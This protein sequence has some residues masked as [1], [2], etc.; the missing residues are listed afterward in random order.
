[1]R[2]SYSYFVLF[3]FVQLTSFS[4]S[5]SF[6]S[7]AQK[8]IGTFSVFHF[9]PI[10]INETTSSE[11]VDLFVKD[12]DNVGIVLKQSDVNALQFNKAQLFDQ[13]NAN[14]EEYFKNAQTI[15]TKALTTVDS[16]LTVLSAKKLNFT[17]NDTARSLS[18]NAKTFYS[19]SIKYH[20]KRLER[21]IKSRS[22]DRVANTDGYEKLTELEFNDKASEFSKT[23]ITNFQKNI[24]EML[25]EANKTVETNLLNAIALRHDPHSN[26]FTQEQN[27]EFNKQL[28]A[29][30]ESFGFYLSEDD[31]GNIKV[32]YIEPG[33]SAW[34]SNE[35]NEGDLFISVRI[36]G[37]VLT[38]DGNTA[39]DIQEKIDKT[40]ENKL[41]LTL[42]K[43]NGQ[44]KTVKL[45]KQ[46]TASVDNTVKG[47]VLKSKSGNIGYISLPSFY[48]DMEQNTAP[49]CA[50]DVAKEILKLEGDSITGLIIDIRNNG[51]GSMLEA[52]N[53]AGIFVDEGPLFIYKE[54]NKKPALVKDINRGSI[55]K[56]PLVVMI[57]ETSASASELFSNIVKDYNLGLVVGQT[58]YGKGTAQNVYP[59]DTNVLRVRNGMATATDFIKVTQAKFYRL[60]NSTHQGTGVV[61]DVVL[62]SSPGYSIYKESKEAFFLESDVV[63]KNVVYTPNPVISV[64][65]IQQKSAE[66]IQ[67]STDFKRYKQ[68][69]DSI[70]D[71]LNNPP[72]LVLKFKEFK[73]Y[74]E[75]SEN[76]YKSYEK[77]VQSTTTDIKCLNNTFDK[78]ITEV[79]EQTKEFNEKVRES[80]EKDLFIN[81]AFYIINDLKEIS[82]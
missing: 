31:D 82:K 19:P 67:K 72:K 74:Q 11:T 80:I 53:L 54:K 12:L 28:S 40:N 56:K 25:A 5:G 8:L 18:L 51:G 14:S 21:N 66:R 57:N 49:G 35:V 2:N 59:L 29:Q 45:I 63:T 13:V 76:L 33:G 6:N 52:V 43:Q 55:F 64:A 32:V 10:P 50:N 38:N 20:L 77:A 27:K 41:E 24:K 36:A 7:K 15:Y 1:M 47:Y 75:Y 34:T 60:N 3:C 23:I 4:Q 30:V 22:Y 17:E 78:K 44:L 81:E 73:K 26:Y 69:S 9:K 65:G 39:E 62:P 68:S 46:K 61:P 16:L 37:N 70:V 48:T 58:S 42:K 79:N 71:F